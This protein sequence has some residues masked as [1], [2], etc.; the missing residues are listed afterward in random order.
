MTQSLMTDR[1]SVMRAGL[2][3]QTASVTFFPAAWNFSLP[4][5][6]HLAQQRNGKIRALINQ[7]WSIHRPWTSVYEARPWTSGA[8]S[9]CITIPR[10][11]ASLLVKR[12]ICMFGKLICLEWRCPMISCSKASWRSRHCTCQDYRPLGEQNSSKRLCC[13]RTRLYRISVDH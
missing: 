9:C 5:S 11:P 8:W 4:R 1:A 7:L 3:V 12:G 10:W 2:L 13:W 6:H